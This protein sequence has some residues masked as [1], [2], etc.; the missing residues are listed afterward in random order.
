MR[1]AQ[2]IAVNVAPGQIGY[3]IAKL[4]KPPDPEAALELI[5]PLKHN[6]K[7]ACVKGLQMS[8]MLVITT[9]IYFE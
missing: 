4:A 9:D 5:A 2:T 1:L 8:V 6:M 3:V 7:R